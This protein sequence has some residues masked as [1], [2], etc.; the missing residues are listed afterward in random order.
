[1]NM[2]LLITGGTGFVG[3]CL[4]RRLLDRGDEV[5]VVGSSGG[6]RS[7]SP[8]DSLHFIQADTREKGG[9]LDNIE[10]Y[11]AIINLTGRTIFNLWSERYKKEIMDS[12]I[13][14]TQ[15]IVNALPMQT[16]V[17]LLNASA[18]GFYGDCG[19]R[20]VDETSPG[21]KDFLA[22][23]CRKWEEVALSAEAKGARVGILRF[24]VV[25]G[26]D[27]GAI[28]TMKTPFK[29][30]LGGPIG[31]GRQWFPWIH[32]DDLL[33]ATLFILDGTDLEGLYNFTS[34]GFVRQKE[35]A[36]ILGSVVN[37]PAF[38][39]TPAFVMKTA[40]GEFGQS[41]LMGQKAYPRAL[42]DKGF[43][44]Q[45]PELREALQEILHD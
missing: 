42:L 45:Y 12:R 37:R 31:S 26:R 21:G 2:K 14:T 27:G 43:V 22:E 3:T 5:W 40:L 17:T 20:E 13:L 8:T 34:P 25:L 19:D 6:Q 32:I 7:D 35:F 11:D 4:T 18:A 28:G 38:L 1:M 23:V 41:L 36:K 16:D 24:G 44:F 10:Q 33:K 30:G 29:L 9:W 15:N 39:P